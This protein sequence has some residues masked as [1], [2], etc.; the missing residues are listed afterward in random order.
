M[1]AAYGSIRELF[2]SSGADYKS[3]KLS[4]G[5]PGRTRRRRSEERLGAIEPTSGECWNTDCRWL[6]F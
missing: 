6:A 1:V 3:L 5:L 4:A 2:N